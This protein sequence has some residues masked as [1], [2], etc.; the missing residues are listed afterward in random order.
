MFKCFESTWEMF[1]CK[2]SW[3][4]AHTGPSAGR[5]TEMVHKQFCQASLRITTA[6]FY[7]TWTVPT[8]VIELHH[9]E[10]SCNR[11][12]VVICD[13]LYRHEISV[14]CAVCGV[15]WWCIHIDFSL[16]SHLASHQSGWLPPQLMELLI[17]LS[18][19]SAAVAHQFCASK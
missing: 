14:Q 17:L 7:W 1:E 16:V 3:P 2:Y 5:Y 11:W 13:N 4:Q 18:I 6:L 12:H 8:P 10:P 15:M 19:D 9:T